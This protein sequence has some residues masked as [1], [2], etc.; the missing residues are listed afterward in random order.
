MGLMHDEAQ[1][2]DTGRCCWDREP[3]PRLIP[4]MLQHK[5]LQCC[6]KQSLTLRPQHKTLQCCWK[7]SL[8]LRPQHKTLQCCWKQSLTLRSLVVGQRSGRVV[9]R[10][11]DQG[12]RIVPG[13]EPAPD[14]G[15][16]S[17]SPE[18]RHQLQQHQTYL[19]TGWLHTLGHVSCLQNE[20]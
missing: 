16:S 11:V 19:C 6:W 18:D 17:L 7:Q 5:T 4:S 8:T 9:D 13:R 2:S 14:V 10:C 15:G 12:L 1:F 20:V 3:N